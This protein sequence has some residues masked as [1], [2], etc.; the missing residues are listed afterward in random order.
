MSPPVGTPEKVFGIGLNKTGTK[1]LG[2]CFEQLGYRNRSWDSDSPRR[3]PSFD[4]Y[5]AGKIDELMAI[6][7]DYDSC[8][9]WPWPLLYCELDERYPDAKFVL[10]LR[11]TPEVWYS[12]LCNMAVRIGP[13][14][15]YERKVYGHAMPQGHRDELIE[16]YERHNA[17]VRAYFES[18]PGKLLEVCWERGDD[19]SDVARFLGRQPLAEST[20]RANVSRQRGV[21]AGDN[22]LLAHLG[23]IGYQRIWGPRARPA[24]YASRAKRAVGRSTSGH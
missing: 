14:P 10:T 1:T 17:E 15:L 5:N 2:Q 7:D 20:P 6:L 8:E 22:A 4:L 18:R 24:R 11:R 13:L 23:R 3:S 21:Y 19:S 12:S 9:D 16:I